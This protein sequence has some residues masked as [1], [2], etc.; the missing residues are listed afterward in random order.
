MKNRKLLIAAWVF[1]GLSLAGNA[2]LLWQRS[3]PAEAPR[4][5]KKPAESGVVFD[6]KAGPV[7]PGGGAKF[8][9]SGTAFEDGSWKL[10]DRKPEKAV[11]LDREFK[12]EEAGLKPA[13]AP[14]SGNN[15]PQSTP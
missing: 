10:D 8:D 6:A 12:W 2:V 1:G 14:E 4:A 15:R 11:Q 7:P 5:D 13:E 9:F 3:R